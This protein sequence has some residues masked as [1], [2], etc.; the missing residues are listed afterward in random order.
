MGA[1]RFINEFKPANKVFNL[2]AYLQFQLQ[3]SVAKLRDWKD[4]QSPAKDPVPPARLR[5]RVHGNLSRASYLEVG[6]NVAKDIADLCRIAGRD[7]YS[8]TDILDFGC[9]CGRVIQNFRDPAKPCNLYATDIDPDLVSWG[10]SNLSDIRWSVNSHH[11]PS[12]FN[13]NSFDLIYCVSVFTH[14]DEDLQHE[15]LRELQ[16]IAR[17]GSTLILTVHGGHHIGALDASYRNEIRQRGFLYITSAEG[18]LKLDGLPD[19]YQSTYHTKEYIHK[20]WSQYFDIVDY[21]E[22]GIN[23]DQDAVLL[24]KPKREESTLG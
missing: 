5:H 16:R 11:A 1:Q 7:F 6:R 19:F 21:V 9:G 20:V 17:P 2:L 15:W 22:R 10:K 12:P 13:D 18:R 3:Y 23:N 4:S 14:L 24:R 8:F